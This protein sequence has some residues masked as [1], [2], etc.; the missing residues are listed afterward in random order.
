MSLSSIFL[1]Q[2]WVID[3]IQW[4][5]ICYCPYLFYHSNC[6]RLDQLNPLQ[7]GS[8]IFLTSPI[9]WLTYWH[10]TECSRLN[11]YLPSSSKWNQPFSFFFSQESLVL[12]AVAGLGGRGGGGQYK[13]PLLILVWYV[14]IENLPSL[15]DSW[16][17]PE[18]EN[19]HQ[20]LPEK[21]IYQNR[22]SNPFLSA[23]HTSLAPKS[24]PSHSC[25]HP[26][27]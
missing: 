27:Q 2:N 17:T 4:F 19:H 8:C 14:V 3:F 11:V 1:S 26:S 6:S 16:I 25:F 9:S 24:F 12:Y 23:G 22:A 13:L 5:T 7:T 20:T 18:P 15:Q 21:W 10:K